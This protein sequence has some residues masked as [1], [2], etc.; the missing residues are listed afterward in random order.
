MSDYN[1]VLLVEQAFTV[2][3]AANLRGLHEDIE[4][5]VVYH[6]LLPVEDAS[7]R[8]ESAMG[9]FAEH[10]RRA[11]EKPRTFRRRAHA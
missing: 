1:V 3:D 2:K 5:P 11:A 8:V 10:P 9:W 7:S 6:V 4:E